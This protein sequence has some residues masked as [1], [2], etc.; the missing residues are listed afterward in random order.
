MA[1]TAM[2]SLRIEAIETAINNLQTAIN[3]LVPRKSLT[4]ISGLLQGLMAGLQSQIDS[5]ETTGIGPALDSHKVD[6]T[7]HTAEH[8]VRY[9]TKA[10]HINS[11][12]GVGDA[13]KA[14]ILDSNGKLNSTFLS[15]SGLE[16][17][18]LGLS[19]TPTH[20]RAITLGA[21]SA[22]T[23]DDVLTLGNIDVPA[24]IKHLQ[25]SGGFSLFGGSPVLL[26]PSPIADVTTGGGATASSNADALNSILSI[27]RNYDIIS[28]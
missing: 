15:G 13:A 21:R 17:L 20:A 12:V 6:V 10:A 24:D 11:T 4:Q 9:Y 8:D 3:N 19:S 26:Q 23:A 18:A 14:V 22:S 25:V 2:E 5:V 28:T 16:S 1:L 7:A 27:L